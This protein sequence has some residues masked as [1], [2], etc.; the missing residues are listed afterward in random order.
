MSLLRLFF[1]AKVSSAS[2]IGCNTA[3]MNKLVAA[4]GGASLYEKENVEEE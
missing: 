1:R 2:L 4:E 3:P